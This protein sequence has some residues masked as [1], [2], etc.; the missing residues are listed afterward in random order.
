MDEKEAVEL[1]KFLKQEKSGDVEA[2]H[3]EADALVM[4]FL[5]SLGH[6]EIV[7]AW[8]EIPKWYA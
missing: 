5:T 6:E 8:K 2:A 4:E 1:L 3:Y 7:Q